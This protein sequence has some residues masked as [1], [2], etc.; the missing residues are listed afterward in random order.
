MKRKKKNNST[1]QKQ[2]FRHQQNVYYKKMKQVMALVGDASA[3]DMLDKIELALL[4]HCR[5]RPYKIINPREGQPRFSEKSLDRFNQ[6]LSDLTHH[7][8][9]E[10]G[11][12]KTKISL[13]DF[14]IYV[15]TLF[16]YWRNVAEDRPELR[17]KFRACFPLFNNNFEEL[18]SDVFE[19]ITNRLEL[20]AWLYSDIT[21]QTIRFVYEKIDKASSAYSTRAYCN[22]Y[23]VEQKKAE[24]EVLEIDGRKRTIYRICM[25][26]KQE[27][28]PLTIPAEKLGIEGIMQKFRLKVFIQ[29]HALHRIEAR[30][31]KRYLFLSYFDVLNAMLGEA[32]PATGNNTYLFPLIHGARKLGYFKGDV[33]GDKLVIRTFLFLTNNG[34]PE[35][36]KL[37]KLFGLQ[38]ADKKYLGIDKLSTFILSDIKENEQLKTLFCEAGCS[39][40]F[41]LD[42]MVLGKSEEKET[43]SSFP[44]NTFVSPRIV[45]GF[46]KVYTL[47]ALKPHSI[48]S[49]D[50]S[51]L[52]CLDF[53]PFRTAIN[54]LPFRSAD[55]IKP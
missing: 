36:T 30:L 10:I 34:T 3:F 20:M 53:I 41:K 18:R 32:I 9:I 7:S 25:N 37:Q 48:S 17:I 45:S 24:T 27:L 23:I 1:Q 35:G 11:E 31:G 49:A 14:S 22:N 26:M 40:L 42:K 13:Y 44:K 19:R 16:L 33:I 55:T 52:A 4:H 15:E 50:S 38:K 8:L 47:K 54:L 46:T 28:I 43:V 6:N 2:E 51:A 5:I 39:D 12:Q 29:Q 21:H